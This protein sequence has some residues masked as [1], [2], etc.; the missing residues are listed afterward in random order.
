MFLNSPGDL[1][2][3]FQFELAPQPLSLFDGMGLMRKG[4][5][6][7]MYKILEALAPC[8]D[9]SRTE[10]C[11]FVIDGGHLLHRVLWPAHATFKSLYT[12]YTK[13][14]QNNFGTDVIIVF[15][16]YQISNTKADERLRRGMKNYCVDIMFSDAMP[17]TVSQE[18]F[19]ANGNNKSRFIAALTS[20]LQNSGYAVRQAVADAD[21]LIVRTAVEL[22]RT[23]PNV[24]V[25]GDDTDLLV[26]LI[27]LANK[28]IN[29]S[30][31]KPG[32]GK[33]PQRNYSSLKLQQALGDMCGC[34]LFVHAATGCDTTCAPY[35]QGKSEVLSYLQI[36]RN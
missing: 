34:L 4:K 3:C 15:D 17:V 12:T 35:R 20:I 19:L 23:Q 13:Y 28:D 31:L 8:E 18:K 30:L 24:S 14:I 9:N 7:D 22:S 25:V 29:V 2:S 6:S 16:G 26:L 5:K 33:I 36:Q 21:T 1:S 11:F 32:R 27:A 10:K